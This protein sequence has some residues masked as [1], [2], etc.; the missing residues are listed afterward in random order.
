MGKGLRDDER[1]LDHI[2]NLLSSDELRQEERLRR[3]SRSG[4]ENNAAHT[5]ENHA[6]SASSNACPR[7][8]RRANNTCFI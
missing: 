8:D 7:C 5:G 3:Y 2:L 6:P 1:E 4:R